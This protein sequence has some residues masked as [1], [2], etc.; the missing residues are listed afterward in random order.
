MKKKLHD[1]TALCHDGN[2][3]YD[4]HGAIVPPIYQNSLYAF[5]SWDDIDIAFEK[6]ADNFIYSRILNPTVSLAEEKIAEICHGERAKLCAS[7]MGAISAAIMH[8]INVGDHI[9]AVTNVYGPTNNF[10]NQYLTKKC[11]IKVSYVKG[12]SIDEFEEAILDTT[13]LIYLE[14]PAS[15]TFDIQ[16]LEA[17]ANLAKS[18]NIKTIIDNTWAT[19]IFQK[20]LDYGIDLECHS[21]SKYLCGHSDVVA[22]VVVGKKEEI[23]S[24]INNEHALFGAKMAPFEAWL[25]L[26]SLRTLTLR[27]KQHQSS[28]I[29]V[30]QWLEKQE[31][32]R[33][34]H[35]PGLQSFPQYELAA[36]QLSGY[37]GLLSLELDTDDLDD[38]KRFVNRLELFKLG[39]SW[40]GHKSLVYSPSISYLKELPPDKFR[41]MGLNIGL[42]RL[43]IGLENPEDLIAD[44]SQALHREVTQF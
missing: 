31:G 39:V 7:G 41:A 2:S 4:H 29:E 12:T 11:G 43:S 32:I 27:M 22:G 34:V 18:R 9:I 37:S 6:P 20:P 40:G 28:T 5:E 3:Y 1:E 36:K 17:V 14:S 44:I 16:D 13:R 15:M 24:I 25:I 33:A 19:P 23:D 38:V 10:L 42:L 35:Y 26:R 21:A 8:C 30:A